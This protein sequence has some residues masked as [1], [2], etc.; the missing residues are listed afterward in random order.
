VVHPLHRARRP[1]AEA[2]T[3]RADA[4]RGHHMEAAPA[5]AAAPVPLRHRVQCAVD[6]DVYAMQLCSLPEQQRVAVVCSDFALRLY[7]Q[8]QLLFAGQCRG[9]T[10]RVHDLSSSGQMLLSSSDDGALQ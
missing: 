7:D 3:L 6:A 5:A 4:S 8:E 1:R 10:E 2:P 9:H